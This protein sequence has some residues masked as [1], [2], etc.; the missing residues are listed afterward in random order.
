MP[1]LT[2][3]ESVAVLALA[4]VGPGEARAC[5]LPSPLLVFRTFAVLF[6]PNLSVCHQVAAWS[7]VCSLPP[8]RCTGCLYLK[9]TY[10]AQNHGL[11][12]LA[13]QLTPSW[14]LSELLPARCYLSVG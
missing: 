9:I 11:R 1:C 13:T 3:V 2:T 6:V 12:V 10:R 5:V 7:F 8:V 4:G 14:V